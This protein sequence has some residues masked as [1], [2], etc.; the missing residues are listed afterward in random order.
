MALEAPANY[1]NGCGF[2]FDAKKAEASGKMNKDHLIQENYKKKGFVAIT[3]AFRDKKTMYCDHLTANGMPAARAAQQAGKAP[4]TAEK[5]WEFLGRNLCCGRFAHDSSTGKLKC[6]L[7]MKGD[8]TTP[9]TPRCASLSRAA[10]I[11]RPR[12]RRTMR[13]LHR[14]PI[15]THACHEVRSYM[16]WH[17]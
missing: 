2:G 6:G 9:A 12:P 11:A 5:V 14:E 13:R 8:T 4:K 16:S 7:V 17:N 15:L 1:V 3:G 10:S